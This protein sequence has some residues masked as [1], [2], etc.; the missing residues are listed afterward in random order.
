MRTVQL[1]RAVQLKFT[2]AAL[3]LSGMALDGRYRLDHVVA[4]WGATDATG[5][6]HTLD[7]TTFPA[8]VL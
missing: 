3:W 4:H 8:E 2:G 1:R 7:G 5:S 6:E